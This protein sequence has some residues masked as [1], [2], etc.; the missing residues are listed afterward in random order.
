MKKRDGR[1]IGAEFSTRVEIPI[2]KRLRCSAFIRDGA[3]TAS[4][5]I[6]VACLRYYRFAMRRGI[7][8][9]VSCLK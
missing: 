1:N 2:S 4:H 8:A 5:P 6:V 7:F 3:L 9:F